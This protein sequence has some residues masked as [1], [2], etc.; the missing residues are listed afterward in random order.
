MTLPIDPTA[1]SESDIGEKRATLHM[2]HESAIEHVREVFTDAGFGVPVEFSPS[3][4]LN[5]KVDAD[6][7][8]YYVLG[9]CNPS[10]AD[11]A[12]DAS[13]KKM[14]GLFP[15]N[16]IIWEEEPGVQTVYHVS[17]M[18]IGRLVG[19]APDDETMAEIVADT[20]ELVDEAFSNLDTEA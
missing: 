9:A 17:I 10:M 1:L 11:R 16:V 4:L 20:G 19:M 2:D 8:P 5:E 18:R 15:C 13:E 12:L 6:R 7:D 14:G 3:E